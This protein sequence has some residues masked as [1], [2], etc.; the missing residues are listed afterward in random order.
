[1]RNLFAPAKINLYLGV[2]TERDERGYHRVDSVM[3]TLDFGDEITIEPSDSLT[4]KFSP[5]IQAATEKTTTYR[6]VEALGKAFQRP[7]NFEIHVKR[8]IPERSGLGGSSTDAGAVLKAICMGWGIGPLDPRVVKVAQRVGADI[9]FFLSP[10]TS[11]LAGTGD[12]LVEQFEAPKLSVVVVRP[13][14]HGSHAQEAYQEFDR[15]PEKAGDLEV[16]LE[17]LRAHDTARI[18]ENISNNLQTACERLEPDLA[19]VVVWLNQQEGAVSAAV[20]GSGACCFALCEKD[21]MAKEIA[22]KAH[23]VQHWWSKSA[24]VVDADSFGIGCLS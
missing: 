1:M 3:T 13:P 12:T 15:H 16:M 20:S 14:I 24:K 4:L 10:H 22:D 18:M 19:A 11:Y 5:A 6:T 7:T 21:E 2:H 23:K 8:G 17:A 9:P